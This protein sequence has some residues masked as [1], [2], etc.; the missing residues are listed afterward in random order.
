MYLVSEALR[1]LAKDKEAELSAEDVT[2][3]NAYK[4]MLDNA[5]EVS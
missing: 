1:L 4:K 2:A 5:F 3:L